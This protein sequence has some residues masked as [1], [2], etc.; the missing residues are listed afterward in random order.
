[1]KVENMHYLSETV[2]TT[3]RLFGS[4]IQL[5]SYLKPYSKINF[6]YI[7][8]LYLIDKITTKS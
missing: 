3:L 4:K 1:M 2:E 7:E 8:K 6:K 5:E